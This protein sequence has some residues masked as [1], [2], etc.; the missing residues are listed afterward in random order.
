[1]TVRIGNIRIDP[2]GGYKQFAVFYTRLFEIAK[3]EL[4]NLI[5]GTD[6]KAKGIS[7]TTGQ[8]YTLDFMNVIGNLVQSKLAPVASV[9]TDFMSGQNY[10]GEKTNIRDPKQWAERIAPFAMRDVWEAYQDSGDK[11]AA[12]GSVAFLGLGVQ[13][14]TGDWNE[15]YVKLGQPKYEDNLVYNITQPYYDVQDFFSDTV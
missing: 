2:W 9:I 5:N 8:E 15:N 1:M 10:A 14:Y 6:Y 3:T 12:I 13:T 7:S 11:G 4:G